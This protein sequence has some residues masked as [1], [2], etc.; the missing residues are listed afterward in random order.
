MPINV[1]AKGIITQEKVR[2]GKEAKSLIKR[3]VG[4]DW[5]RTGQIRDS[6][7]LLW[8]DKKRLE[9]GE[10]K[11]DEPA[12]GKVTLVGQPIPSDWF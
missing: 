1:R 10:L 3:K 9:T 5:A 4:K 8:T 11:Y 7:A 12:L 6:T 2:T